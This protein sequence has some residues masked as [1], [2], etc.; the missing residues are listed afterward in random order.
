MR[1][2]ILILPLMLLFFASFVF[3]DPV[4][5]TSASGQP[6]DD[7]DLRCVLAGVSDIESLDYAYY[8]YVN[9][10]RTDNLADKRV[11]PADRSNVDDEV[12]CAVLDINLDV[13]GLATVKIVPTHINQAPVVGNIPNVLFAS[14]DSANI[15]LNNFVS[16]DTTPDSEIVWTVNGA[17]ANVQVVINNGVAVLTSAAD[18]SGKETLTFTATDREGLT[19]SDA[20]VVTVFNIEE[21]AT[22]ND[23]QFSQQINDFFRSQR[24]FVILRITAGDEG[25]PGLDSA[26]MILSLDNANG[27][28]AQFREFSGR[29]DDLN[30]ENGEVC[31]RRFMD[32]TCMN[33][34]PGVYFYVA[35]TNLPLTDNVLGNAILTASVFDNVLT[36]QVQV[37]NNNPTV[38]LGA[39]F[40]AQVNNPFNYN[41]LSIV[42][43]LEDASDVLRFAWDFDNDGVVDSNTPSGNFAY[44]AEGVYTLSVV[45]TDSDG[46]S[47]TDTVLVTVTNLPPNQ[48][49]VAVAGPDRTVAL[50]EQ[51]GFD[52]SLSSDAEGPIVVYDW[53]FGDGTGSREISP[54]H[55]Y[56]AEGTYTVVLTVTDSEG[57][58]D[59]DEA[60]IVA[61]RNV[62]PNQAPVAVAGDDKLVGVE[63]STSFDGSRSYDSDGRVVRHSWNFGDGETTQGSF[64][65]HSYAEAGNY[66]VTLTVTDN[67][68]AQDTDTLVVTVDSSINRGG[69]RDKRFDVWSGHRESHD[70][71]VANIRDMKG[72]TSF[73]PGDVVSLLV[74]VNNEG[75]FDESLQL[76]FSV[77]EFNAYDVAN[78]VNLDV[79]QNR[80]LQL[81]FVIPKNANKGYH[82]GRLTL[83]NVYGGSKTVYWPFIVN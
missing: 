7:Q 77:P 47:A 76:L 83:N 62:A 82:V 5:I 68:G 38:E 32:P 13:K 37:L 70:F 34:A 20:S 41:G 10:V 25:V 72:R 33:G 52:G 18:F 8:W 64:V 44:V 6:A 45:V 42:S 24:V 15:D 55:V 43:D 51:V 80:L 63:L 75:D 29:V 16:D 69:D 79:S 31:G 56:A 46:G 26:R 1:A 53:N 40:R 23:A 19:D 35:T 66:L 54:S 17:N 12:T 2:K 11:L 30:V 59:N 22:F 81:E 27:N 78:N 3:A 60:V 71:R 61:S 48:A 28:V 67:D 49:P 74:N 14:G 58:T 21:I 36:H 4:S 39:D 57:A 50:N 9:G 73:S 65:T